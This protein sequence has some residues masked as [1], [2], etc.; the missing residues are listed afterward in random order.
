MK[1]LVNR[2]LSTLVWIPAARIAKEFPGCGWTPQEKAEWMLIQK[3]EE[4]YGEGG[5]GAPGQEGREVE[6]FPR[7]GD[8]C[9]FALRAGRVRGDD[10]E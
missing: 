10:A 6:G 8:V 3:E 2:V 1:N 9:H 7:P 4:Y 5:S